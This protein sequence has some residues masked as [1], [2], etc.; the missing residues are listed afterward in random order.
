[1]FMLL[2]EMKII[3]IC[4]FLTINFYENL[5]EHFF[6]FLDLEFSLS[7]NI[8]D[9]YAKLKKLQI[10][11]NVKNVSYITKVTL[12]IYSEGSSDCTFIP[13]NKFLTLHNF[14]MSIVYNWT[15][16]NFFIS[17]KRLQ[18]RKYRQK[19]GK[20]LMKNLG[21]FCHS[22]HLYYINH[23]YRMCLYDQY[24]LEN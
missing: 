24:I 17:N 11:Q 18:N 8:S 16:R 13:R 4:N 19:T 21:W 10:P 14:Y 5:Q 23:W 7:I 3:H 6:C 2:I 12:P 9:L 20:I 22:K 1:M 15:S